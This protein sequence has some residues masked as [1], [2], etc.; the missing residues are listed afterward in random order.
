M[1]S[2]IPVTQITRSDLDATKTTIEA[3]YS[4]KEVQV[5]V[6]P[7]LAVVLVLLVS[8]PNTYSIHLRLLG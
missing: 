1:V 2:T 4:N 5:Y 6:R 7:I 3:M 8:Q